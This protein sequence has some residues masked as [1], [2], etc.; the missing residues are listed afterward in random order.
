MTNE[1]NILRAV[2]MMEIMPREQPPDQHPAYVYLARLGSGSRRTM[3][4]ALNIVAKLLSGGRADF[5]TIP[6]DLLRY[7]HTAGVRAALMEK[8]RPSTA[9][10]IISALRGVLREAWR[11]GLMSAEDF[12]RA[13]DIPAIRAQTLPKGRALSAGEL[14]ALMGA[15]GRDRS[16]AGARD[17]ALVALL[18]G[19]GLRRSESVGLDVADF[20]IDSGQL[21]IRGKGR[22]D[23][24]GYATNGIGNALTDWLVVRGVD[25]GP[26]FSGINKA[27]RI[28]TCRMTD[29]AVF[30][31]LKK[32]ADQAGVAAFSPHDMRRS[33]ISDLLD[34]GADIGAIDHQLLA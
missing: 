8:Y 19:A 4:G 28:A 1:M 32:R 20:N 18:Y 30:F 3:R 25:P 27:G 10:K 7:Q 6:W 21:V 14:S 11:L 9:N 33:F 34:A 16:A 13:A 2:P 24:I 15:C 22:K 26:I 5:I 29:Q 17:S 12:H 31:I 23:R